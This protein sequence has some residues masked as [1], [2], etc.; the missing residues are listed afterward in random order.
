MNIEFR[1]VRVRLWSL[2]DEQ[3]AVDQAKAEAGR[4][5]RE[6][7]MSRAAETYR[8]NR[9]ELDA[10]ASTCERA[11]GHHREELNVSDLDR[12]T[13]SRLELRGVTYEYCPGADRWI[14]A[15]GQV[16]KPGAD[17][18][19]YGY[20]PTDFA[21]ALLDEL[22]D[23]IYGSANPG[24][25]AAEE[26]RDTIMW[27]SEKFDAYCRDVAQAVAEDRHA[28]DCATHN[29]PAMPNGECDCGAFLNKADYQD[30]KDSVMEDDGFRCTF[31]CGDVVVLKSGGI[32]MTV[33]DLDYHGEGVFTADLIW[34]DRSGKLWELDGLDV[35]LLNLVMRRDDA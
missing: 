24:H 5:S 33:E 31:H 18:L 34:T 21:D 23:G 7:V 30:F 13:V 11:P 17:E 22:E 35:R 27:P 1:P 26:D 14:M 19:R 9:A 32:W 20:S 8:A 4:P 6:T 15:P 12:K 16:L 25:V 10:F 28:S 29:E 2:A 3:A